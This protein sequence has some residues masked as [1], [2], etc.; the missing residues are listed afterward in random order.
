MS[1]TSDTHK[2]A[3]KVTMEAHQLA[4]ECYPPTDS[5]DESF[6]VLE[7]DSN[8]GD[9]RKDDEDFSQ[10]VKSQ[11]LPSEGIDNALDMA[12]D[13]MLSAMTLQSLPQMPQLSMNQSFISTTSS[14][15]SIESKLLEELQDK[16]K[17]LKEENGILR[18]MMAQQ[19][20]V[21]KS[22]SDI[23]TSWKEDVCRVQE[24]RNQK[25][26]KMKVF[27]DQLRKENKQL[28]EMLASAPN[29]ANASV[30]P[31]NT[32]SQETIQK[33][34][35][36]IKELETK[37]DK[38]IK[39]KSDELKL[40]K[41]ELEQTK[42]KHN[43]TVRDLQKI[44]YEF[45]QLQDQSI[46]IVQKE[47]DK[48]LTERDHHMKIIN[49]LKDEKEA[50]ERQISG[51]KQNHQDQESDLQQRLENEVFTLK[52]KLADAEKQVQDLQNTKVDLNNV[53]ED[54]VTTKELNE[55]Q[56][57]RIKD[58]KEKLAE[59]SNVHGK[60]CG[61]FTKA[62]QD[63]AEC[64]SI[65]ADRCHEVIELQSEL[66]DNRREVVA[67]KASVEGKIYLEEQ[68][69]DYVKQVNANDEDYKRVELE[70]QEAAKKEQELQKENMLMKSQ[71]L[72]MKNDETAELQRLRI[73]LSEAQNSLIETK[74]AKKLSDKEAVCNRKAVDEMEKKFMEARCDQ[75]KILALE[76][77]LK[78]YRADYKA[79]RE[80]KIFVVEELN[81][82]SQDL[83][84]VQLR[85]RELVDEIERLRAAQEF[86]NVNAPQAQPKSHTPSPPLTRFP[87]PL[88]GEMFRSLRLLEEHVDL[89]I[90]TPT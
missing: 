50:M 30:P 53:S 81:K 46:V 48:L 28:K 7:T 34:E 76:E 27:V 29:S 79:E 22:H 56:T 1:Q 14:V 72:K 19:S 66:E 21:T 62:K 82:V 39:D 80:R 63:Y 55:Q 78:I 4:K 44:T 64:R 45:K 75:D 83:E 13:A 77:Q 23:L 16:V 90:N 11:L 33:L 36:Q 43:D 73:Q 40:V 47:Q 38:E 68:L 6:E 35:Q 84:N 71:L 58:L 37:H 24:A 65:L 26:E 70:N 69:A 5:D 12:N 10:D 3:K 61:E 86:V 67:L 42:V 89:C 18:N 9:I 87:C 52:K 85:N 31:Q 59:L 2:Q 88:C 54:L 41:E 49:V 20:L 32:E 57:L 60:M 74:E 25:Y 51:I 17:N 8:I 15:G